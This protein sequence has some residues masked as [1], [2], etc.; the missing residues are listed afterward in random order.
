MARAYVFA[1]GSERNGV[2]YEQKRVEV[3]YVMEEGVVAIV[4]A[5]VFYGK[6]QASRDR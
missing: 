6:W 4:T 3:Y 1:Y 5:Y 2:Y